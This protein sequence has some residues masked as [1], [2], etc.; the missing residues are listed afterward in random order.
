MED[1]VLDML[2]FPILKVI[3]NLPYN[4]TTPI[5]AKLLPLKNSIRSLVI[6]VQHEVAK[7]MTAIPGSKDYGS[8]SVF[9][10]YHA[11]AEYAFKV[12]RTCFYPQPKVDSAIVKLTVREPPQISNREKCLALIRSAFEQR[13]K[14]LRGTWGKEYGSDQVTKSLKELG[15][16]PQ[17]RPEELS[18]GE[19]IAL[20]E[21]LDDS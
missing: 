14:M 20:F 6:M 3:A 1:K 5:L 21:S 9:I 17:A 18:L 2:V 15:L 12:N 16:N 4:I 8:L 13:R 10:H 11:K 19:F 7:R